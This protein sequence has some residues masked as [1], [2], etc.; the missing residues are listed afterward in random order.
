MK[1][2]VEREFLEKLHVELD[3]TWH[4][5]VT[6]IQSCQCPECSQHR[7]LR[8]LLEKLEKILIN[9]DPETIPHTIPTQSDPNP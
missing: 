1:I 3:R 5:H 4:A 8:G 9:S 2:L 7:C 6:P